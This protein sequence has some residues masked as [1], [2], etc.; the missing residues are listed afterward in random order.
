MAESGSGPPAGPAALA[1]PE[2]VAPESEAAPGSLPEVRVENV[3]LHIGGGPDD[4]AAE[5]PYREAIAA[6]FADFRRCYTRIA[7]PGKGGVFGVDLRIGRKGGRPRMEQVRTGMA[8]KEFRDCVRGVFS[9]VEFAPPQRGPT[10]ISYSL[11]FTVGG[12]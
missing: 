3:G 12:R 9:Q 5:A 6:H 8:G 11:R 1:A 4:D 10:V 2:Q 7:T